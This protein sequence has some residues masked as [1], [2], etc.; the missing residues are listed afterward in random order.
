MLFGPYYLSALLLRLFGKTF[1]W[2]YCLVMLGLSLFMA[3]N[4]VSI[5]ARKIWDDQILKD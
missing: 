5:N 2:S 1:N 4:Y 3:F